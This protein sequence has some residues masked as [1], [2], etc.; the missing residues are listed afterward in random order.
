MDMQAGGPLYEN[1]AVVSLS[2]TNRTVDFLSRYSAP[3]TD[4]PLVAHGKNF[5]KPQVSS[6]DKILASSHKSKFQEEIQMAMKRRRRDLDDESSGEKNVHHAKPESNR[7]NVTATDDYLK[8][9]EE[10][11]YVNMNNSTL[12]SA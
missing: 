10:N 4:A 8:V 2:V 3:V 9:I 11:E 12:K 5:V 7:T 6:F 1:H